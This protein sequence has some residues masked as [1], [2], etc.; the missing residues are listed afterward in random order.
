MNDLRNVLAD[1]N[2]EV[3]D[4]LSDITPSDL[5]RVLENFVNGGTYAN[6]VRARAM[7]VASSTITLSPSG[8]NIIVP[9]IAYCVSRWEF[10]PK[11]G[12][13]VPIKIKGDDDEVVDEFVINLQ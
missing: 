5:K 4:R 6:V 12:D 2:K 11:H 7:V 3:V 1:F 8:L 9:P 10:A 13:N